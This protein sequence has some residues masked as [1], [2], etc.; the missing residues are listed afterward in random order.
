MKNLI[1]G[2]KYLTD[3]S[4]GEEGFFESQSKGIQVVTWVRHGWHQECGEPGH[5]TQDPESERGSVAKLITTSDI[6]TPLQHPPHFSHPSPT[7]S[8]LHS[9]GLHLQACLFDPLPLDST[10]SLTPSRG[11]S[12]ETHEPVRDIPHPDQY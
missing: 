2:T 4:Y 7:S 8:L 12:V 6:P 3:S 1:A 10:S 11:P 9:G 5:N